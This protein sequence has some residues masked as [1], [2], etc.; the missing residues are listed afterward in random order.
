LGRGVFFGAPGM[1][2]YFRVK[3]PNT[4]VSGKC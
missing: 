1:A 2:R 3:V 4:P